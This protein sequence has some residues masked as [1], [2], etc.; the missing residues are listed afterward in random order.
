MP[1]VDQP[2]TPEQAAAH[3]NI[4]ALTQRY[5]SFP[6]YWT[7]DY[8]RNAFLLSYEKPGIDGYD[9][10]GRYAFCWNRHVFYFEAK[11]HR[12][13]VTRTERRFIYETSLVV[14]PQ[15]VQVERDAVLDAMCNALRGRA[16]VPAT[17]IDLKIFLK[18][19]YQ[20]QPTVLWSIGGKPPAIQS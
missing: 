19:P 18:D 2:I 4:D 12:K 13:I 14:L 11:S 5:G 17:L 3:A 8:Q 20:F 16:R 7:A 10:Q 15:A 6:C 9:N 1:F